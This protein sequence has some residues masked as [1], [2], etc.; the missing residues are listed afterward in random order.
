[1]K[2]KLLTITLLLLLVISSNLIVSA[3]SYLPHKQNTDLEFSIGSNFATDCILETINSPYGVNTINLQGTKIDKSFKFS[4]DGSNYSSLGTYCHIISCSDGVNSV[5]NGECYI[6]TPDG[7]I[8]TQSKQD[9]YYLF[10]IGIALLIGFIVGGLGLYNDKR[11][12]V[13]A[14]MGFLVAGLVIS[15]YPNGIGNKFVTDALS[16]LNY[17]LAFICLA[18]GIYEWLPEDN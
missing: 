8:N 2:N 18:V 10:F 12:L 1:M 15:Y 4:I 14:A 16:I 7:N 5:T 6:I 9:I 3:E 17:G 13:F 11:L